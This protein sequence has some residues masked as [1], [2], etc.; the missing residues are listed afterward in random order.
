M[1]TGTNDYNDGLANARPPGVPRNSL[2][3]AGAAKL[4][5]SWN[6]AFAL[7]FAKAG[8]KD[9]RPRASLSLEA[10]NILNRVNLQQFVGDLS[11]PFFGQPI[12]AAPARRVQAIFRVKF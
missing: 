9:H 12:A 10:F 7:P 4:D 11:S 5:V 6:K 3:G 1:T 8:S 2:E